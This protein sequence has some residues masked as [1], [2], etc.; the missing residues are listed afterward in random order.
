ME[1]TEPKIHGKYWYKAK[2]WWNTLTPKG[3]AIEICIFNDIGI[4]HAMFMDD[5]EVSDIMVEDCYKA[6]NY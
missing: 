1:D 3:K 2:E 4:D 6:K 5:F